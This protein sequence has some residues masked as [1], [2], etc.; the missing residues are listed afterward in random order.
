MM[1]LL[2]AILILVGCATNKI[3]W[4]SRV[5]TYTFDQAVLE[6]GPPDKIATLTDGTKVAE[7]LTSRG[8]S[9]G[10]VHSFGSPYYYSPFAHHHYYS[11]TPSP[12][13]F[14]RLTFDPEG[15]LT[16]WKKVSK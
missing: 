15:R 4:N 11:E 9:H 1:L 2:G 8:Y 13:Y 12:D 6:L 10:M 5:G 14:V 7:W 16:A 3:D